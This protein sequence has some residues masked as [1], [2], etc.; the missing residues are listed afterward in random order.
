[1]LLTLTVALSSN[2]MPCYVQDAAGAGGDAKM[3][4]AMA[5]NVHGKRAGAHCPWIGIY[6][7]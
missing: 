5:F 3:P 6:V 1:L 4:P 7:A 2:E